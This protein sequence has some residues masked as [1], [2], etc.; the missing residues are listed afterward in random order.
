M[1][2]SLD[3]GETFIKYEGNPIV[4]SDKRDF[5]DPKVFWYAP[6]KHWVMI[7][8]GGQEMDIYT[9]KNLKEWKYES[10]FG[11]KQGAHGGVWE[12]PDLVELPVEGTDEKKWVLICNIN[13][14]GP[15]GGNAAQYFVGTFNGRKFVNEAPTQT[16]WMD[17]GK[18][19]Y[20]TVTFS[21]APDGRCIALG[22]MSNWQYQNVLPTMQFRGSNTIARD[23]TLYRQDGELL[24]RCAPSPEIEQAR[25]ER[26]DIKSFK[27]KDSYEI[28]SLL[29][30]NGG[31][32]EIDMTIKNA[33]ASRIMFA[34]SN[35]KGEKVNMYYDVMRKQFVMD[36]SES[37][38]VDFS[39]DFPAVTVAPVAD[40]DNITLRL[41]VDRSSIEA[42]G[43][44]GKFVM[45]NQIFPSEPYNKL[46]FTSWRGH[47]TV[48]SMTVY[49]IKD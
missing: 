24:L 30:D 37:G 23:L 9:S 10:S 38:K 8:A 49:R 27:T 40:T 2:Y 48:K 7:L 39:A 15:F 3:N 1:A 42:F 26:V 29:D 13:P 17:W 12:C 34:L 43:D 6:G 20:A 25:K 28:P 11:A 33:G 22:W 45:T 31:A 18:D 47:F 35:S 36:R 19:H 21:G 16:K 14:G 4:I 46:S 32:Y 44:G 41:F 5:R